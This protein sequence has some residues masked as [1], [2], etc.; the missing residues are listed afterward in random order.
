MLSSSRF[1]AIV[2]ARGVREISHIVTIRMLDL[3]VGWFV[4]FFSASK[5]E[6]V[7]MLPN[8]FM[9]TEKL[10]RKLIIYGVAFLLVAGCA[11]APKAPPPHPKPIARP[12]PKPVDAKAQQQYYDLGLQNYSKENY[13]GAKEAFQQVIELGPHTALGLKA[14]ENLKKIEQILKTLEEIESK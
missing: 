10:L 1:Y 14:Q 8:R 6:Q 9:T 4:L 13:R 11:S 12:Q 5:R 3:F 2:M 7:T